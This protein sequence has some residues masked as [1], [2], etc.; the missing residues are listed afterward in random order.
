MEIDDISWKSRSQLCI[1]SLRKLK[2][3][4]KSDEPRRVSIYL[5]P[6]QSSSVIMNHV[7]FY[8]FIMYVCNEN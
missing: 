1:N 2:V 4:N 5:S 7:I 3:K 8:T 6:H